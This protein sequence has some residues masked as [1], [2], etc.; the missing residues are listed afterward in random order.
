MQ[1]SFD[2]PQD[3]FVQLPR[4]LRIDVGIAFF[5]FSLFKFLFLDLFL[6]E[7]NIFFLFNSCLFG[8][9]QAE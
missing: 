9:G 3:Y 1:D 7:L 6:L 5:N 2:L 8:N 4:D